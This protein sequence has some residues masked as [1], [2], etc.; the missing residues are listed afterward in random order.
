[1]TTQELA[2]KIFAECAKDGEPVTEAEALEMA[3]ME[4]KSKANCRRYETAERTPAEKS[5]K[6]PRTVKI[7]QEKQELFSFLWEG[8]SNY[9]ENSEILTN[10]KLIAVKIGEKSFKINISEDRQKKSK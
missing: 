1:M 3:E 2:K 8:L 7:S 4:L 5:D 6:K 9:Y 10:N